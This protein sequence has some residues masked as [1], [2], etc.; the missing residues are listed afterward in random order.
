VTQ[1]RVGELAVAG[2]EGEVVGLGDRDRPADVACGPKTAV[3]QLR[4]GAKAPAAGDGEVVGLSDGDRPA[5]IAGG[6]AAPVPLFCT[7]ALKRTCRWAR[8]VKLLA[9][10]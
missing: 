3:A 2:S 5:E 9:L 4:V 1:L 6:V 8:I 7:L 10:V